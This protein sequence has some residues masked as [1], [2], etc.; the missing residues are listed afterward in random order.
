MNPVMP[1][2]ALGGLVAL[3]LGAKSKRP[4]TVP[5]LPPYLPPA[6]SEPPP[7]PFELPPELEP[8][9]PPQR[10][11]GKRE[12]PQAPAAPAPAAP[13]P[14]PASPPQTLPDLAQKAEEIFTAPSPPPPVATPPLPPIVPSTPATPG[15]VTVTPPPTSPS[16][17][18]ATAPGGIPAGYDPVKARRTAPRI[19]QHLKS[20]GIANYSR[21]ALREFQTLAG[22]KPDGIYGG[23]TAGALRYYLGGAKPPAP[24]FKP[25]Q[26]VPYT[27]PGS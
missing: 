12:R 4:A 9:P 5:M 11:Q 24:M 22:I 23:Q 20:K 26:E 27:P 8:A 17:P 10:P 19:A 1:L 15:P 3:A 16:I 13:P 21:Q 6:A 2:L 18:V 14:A 25:V 7:A